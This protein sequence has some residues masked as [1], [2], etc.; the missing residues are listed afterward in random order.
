MKKTTLLDKLQ[1]NFHKGPLVTT[2]KS[3]ELRSH[4]DIT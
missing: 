1:N 4:Y 3:F 2:Y